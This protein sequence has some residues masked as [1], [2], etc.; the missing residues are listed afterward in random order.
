MEY[1]PNPEPD[2]P[3]VQVEMLERSL[4]ERYRALVQWDGPKHPAFNTYSAQL[5]SFDKTW[6]HH[7]AEAFS[8]VGFF[9]TGTELNITPVQKHYFF[10]F[11][12]IYNYLSSFY[13]WG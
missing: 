11:T 1:R 2:T 4:A 9:C 7:N 8:A 13:R 3:A 6:P 10:Y 5:Q 12:P